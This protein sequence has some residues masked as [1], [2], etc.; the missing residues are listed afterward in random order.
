M[1]LG[2]KLCFLRK[3]RGISQLELAEILNVSRQAVS[4]WEQGGSTPSTE[5]LV[6]LGR[7]YD[8]SVDVLVNDDLQLPLDGTQSNEV[9]PLVIGKLNR[10]PVLK[11]V[12]IAVCAFAIGMVISTFVYHMVSGSKQEEVIT[13]GEL[14]QE[15]VDRSLIEEF[16]IQKGDADH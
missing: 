7:L 13:W 11:R 14:E 1:E 3:K 6:S 9:P 16:T 10:W 8:I 12:I 5:N 15:G 4:R 2:E